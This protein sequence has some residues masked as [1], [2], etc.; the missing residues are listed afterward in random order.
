MYRILRQFPVPAIAQSF[1]RVIDRLLF[2]IR[3]CGGFRYLAW[4]YLEVLYELICWPTGITLA[5]RIFPDVETCIGLIQR[6]MLG[7]RNFVNLQQ[8]F[9][10]WRQQGAF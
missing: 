8:F 6:E 1:R 10:N 4:L 5:H 2:V 7:R 3:S 9:W